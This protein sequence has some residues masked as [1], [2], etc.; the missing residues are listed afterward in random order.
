MKLTVINGSPRGKGSNTRLL[1]GHFLKGFSE[2]EEN[3]Y[4][5]VYLKNES[6]PEVL[7]GLFREA[8]VLILGFPLYT[9][10]MPGIVKQFVETLSPLCNTRQDLKIG[11]I[12]QS[13]FPESVHSRYVARYLKKLT[14]RLGCQYLGTVIKGGVEGIQIMPNWMRKKTLKY[15]YTL[16]KNLAET[17]TFDRKI[18]EKMLKPERFS[19][20]RIAGFKVM[21]A[22]GF[23]NWYWNQQLK[24]NG[25]FEKRFDTPY[26]V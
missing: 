16:G 5:E 24:K 2:D 13:G 17:G 26:E 7:T 21:N 25:A 10:A 23:T 18:T 14:A 11:Y 6:N 12:V 1:F 3:K 22:L 4:E 8:E 19:K 20:T 15:F 9:D